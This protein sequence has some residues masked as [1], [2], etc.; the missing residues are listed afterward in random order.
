MRNLTIVISFILISGCST[1]QMAGK[2]ENGIYSNVQK[3]FEMNVPELPEV[4]VVDGSRPFYSYVDF[5]AKNKAYSIEVFD[6]A[7]PDNEESFRLGTVSFMKRYI[8]NKCGPNS[9]DSVIGKFSK[10]SNK[11]SYDFATKG[12]RPDGQKT[13]W[14]GRSIYLAPNKVAIC[15][16][17]VNRIESESVE[18]FKSTFD[19][20]VFDKVCSSIKAKR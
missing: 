9:F 20:N 11:L 15:M 7:S 5:I 2:L 6:R 3:T 4:K 16:F 14:Y 19:K 1:I 18:G 12:V 10:V 13:F 17:Y 8:P